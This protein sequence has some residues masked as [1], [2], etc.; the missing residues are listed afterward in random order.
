L[1]DLKLLQLFNEPIELHTSY[2]DKKQEY[3]NKTIELLKDNKKNT[4]EALNLA[5]AILVGL[6][7]S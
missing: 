1:Q 2:W 4:Q 5:K 7:F 6:L 3:I